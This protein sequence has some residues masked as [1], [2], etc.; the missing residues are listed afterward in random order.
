MRRSQTSSNIVLPARHDLWPVQ[1][2]EVIRE[3]W[4]PKLLRPTSSPTHIPP[5]IEWPMLG[6]AIPNRI[7]CFEASS[8][9]RA[10]SRVATIWD[11][12]RPWRVKVDEFRLPEIV[13]VKTSHRAG[14]ACQVFEYGNECSCN[15]SDFGQRYGCR[16][17]SLEE[18]KKFAFG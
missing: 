6:K 2:N 8:C 18:L 1:L 12:G 9:Q 11:L 15:Q 7:F 13:E 5:R 17:D 14:W 3:I 16:A 4:R 10:G